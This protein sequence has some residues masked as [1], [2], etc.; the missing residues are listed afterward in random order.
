MSITTGDLLMLVRLLEDRLETADGVRVRERLAVDKDLLI[1]WRTLSRVLEHEV[2]PDDLRAAESVR[3]EQMAAFVEERLDPREAARL[4]Q[5][6]WDHPALLREVVSV[7]RER[8]GIDSCRDTA[9]SSANGRDCLSA[10]FGE[11]LRAPSRQ[12]RCFVAATPGRP[13]NDASGPA[14]SLAAGS[15]TPH[16]DADRMAR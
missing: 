6:C 12:Q 15:D 16:S 14:R 4:E 1:G 11:C 2:S 5:T 13:A 9:G 3:P 8:L 10:M 7:F